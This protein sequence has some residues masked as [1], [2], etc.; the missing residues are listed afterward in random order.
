MTWNLKE[1]IDLDYLDSRR[2]SIFKTGYFKRSHVQVDS[3][4]LFII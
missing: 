1:E 3:K 2:N 4:F